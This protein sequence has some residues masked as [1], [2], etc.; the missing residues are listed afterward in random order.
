MNHG[1]ATFQF[2]F[3]DKFY[4]IASKKNWIKIITLSLVEMSS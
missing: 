3:V 4:I 1:L 2:L